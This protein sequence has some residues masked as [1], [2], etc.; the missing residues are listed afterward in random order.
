MSRICIGLRH[1]LHIAHFEDARAGEI[2]TRIL[3]RDVSSSDAVLACIIAPCPPL[4]VWPACYQTFMQTLDEA[5]SSGALSPSTLAVMGRLC[6]L[7]GLGLLEPGMG[8]LLEAGWL[9]GE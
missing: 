6:G 9:S 1:E 3:V 4:R 5:R 7:F 8:D 2:V